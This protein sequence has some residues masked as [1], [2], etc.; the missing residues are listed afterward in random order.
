MFQP[1]H[2]EEMFQPE[3]YDDMFR[4]EHYDDMFPPEH[5]EEMFQ[6]EHCQANRLRKQ[7]SVPVRT[8]RR[9]DLTFSEQP[10]RPMRGARMFQSEHWSGF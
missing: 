1:E 4:L 9:F 2:S 7:L 5:S 8:F 3:H 6:P 10:T